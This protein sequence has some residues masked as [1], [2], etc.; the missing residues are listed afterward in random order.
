MTDYPPEKNRISKVQNKALGYNTIVV[1]A[2]RSAEL[3][4]ADQFK[5]LKQH[6]PSLTLVT[7]LQLVMVHAVIT[8]FD[9]AGGRISHF[10]SPV[11]PKLDTAVSA[12][13]QQARLQAG[14]YG[15]GLTPRD[16]RSPCRMRKTDN[17][18][19]DPLFGITQPTSVYVSAQQDFGRLE[20]PL[21]PL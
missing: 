11:P 7:V 5:G 16:I 20:A 13:S 12:V 8:L 1:N 18:T 19:P 9:G 4:V 6:T 10:D 21:L 15:Q 17:R 14:E 3:P 2:E